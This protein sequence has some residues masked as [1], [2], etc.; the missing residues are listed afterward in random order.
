[1]LDGMMP[2]IRVKDQFERRRNWRAR[3]EY[4]RLWESTVDTESGGTCAPIN[5]RGWV[6]R[7]GMPQ[8]YL[9]K[10]LVTDPETGNLGIR[11]A[12]ALEMWA[13]D[14]EQA[15]KEYEQRL[16]NDALMLFGEAGPKNYE[17]RIP[18][19]LNYT[20]PA[21]QPLEPVLAALAG[22]QWALG[23]S[24]KDPNHIKRFYPKQE[25][26]REKFLKTLQPDADE[27]LLDIEEQH[28]PQA[29]GGKKEKVRKAKAVA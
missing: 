19:L 17:D 20:G 26:A 9:T 2:G 6:D 13:S 1:M 16:Y 3:D 23:L 12:P 28:D 7:L 8:K 27:E 25:T 22:D 29:T 10:A 5:P 11:L 14:L 18:A 24:D 4:G 21:P 15:H